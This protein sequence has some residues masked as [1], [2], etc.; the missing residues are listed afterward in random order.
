M[1]KMTKFMSVALAATLAAASLTACGG[2]GKAETKAET[3]AAGEATADGE[4][5]TIAGIGPLT[6]DAASYGISVKQGAEVA[7]NEINAAG[8][9]QVGDT[10]YTLTLIFEDDEATEEKL[11]ASRG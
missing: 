9:V 7:I 11:E 10:T 6:G 2:S 3:K 8:G 5:F 4:V 1:K